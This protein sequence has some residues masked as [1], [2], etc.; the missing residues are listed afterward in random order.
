LN[1]KSL[2]LR[3]KKNE[4]FSIKPYRDKL[5]FLTIGYG[6]LI[7]HYEKHLTDK[8]L[9]K[10]DLEKIFDDDF[11]KA[12][13]DFNLHLRTLYPNKQESELLIEMVFQIGLTGVLKFKKLLKNMSARKKY[14]VCFE[15]M[16]SLWYKQTPK[17]V[18]FLIKEFLKNEQRR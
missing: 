6:H 16:N 13:N 10:K 12:V 17:R 9:R 15:M 1:Y 11:N 3:I 4:G 8:K 5:G 18:K 2:K 7:L 14:L